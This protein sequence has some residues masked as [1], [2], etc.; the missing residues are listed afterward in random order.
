MRA[1][2]LR[3]SSTRPALRTKRLSLEEAVEVLPEDPLAQM[4]AV[5]ILLR[6]AA[7]Q[8]A[9]EEDQGLAEQPARRPDHPALVE[10]DQRRRGAARERAVVGGVVAIEDKGL[11]GAPDHRRVGVERIGQRRDHRPFVPGH[12][13]MIAVGRATVA[14][15]VQ[16]ADQQRQDSGVLAEGRAADRRVGRVAVL[17][18]EAGD[19]GLAELAIVAFGVRGWRGP[20]ASLCCRSARIRSRSARRV[21]RRGATCRAT[22]ADHQSKSARSRCSVERRRLVAQAT[23]VRGARC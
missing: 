16:P 13:R 7:A 10:T 20:E 23:K 5:V 8:F 11:E 2:P 3:F 15:A 17:A 22:C 19:V 1:S 21:A 9:R 4:G 12:G 6:V 14:L 18:G